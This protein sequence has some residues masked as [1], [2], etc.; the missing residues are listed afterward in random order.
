M[1]DQAAGKEQ[2]V[3]SAIERYE[4]ALMRYAV[5]LTGDGDVARDVVQDTF[6][7][8]WQADPDRL[9]D[10]LAAWLFKV[11]R[12]RALDE[13]RK[14]HR[15]GRI[16]QVPALAGGSAAPDVGALAEIGATHREVLSV[17]ATLPRGQ[18]EVV[19]LRFQGDLSYK[20]ISQVTGYSVGNVGYL[21]HTAL[22]AVRASMAAMDDELRPAA[23]GRSLS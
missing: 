17:L 18:Q 5:S 8:L 11:C 1:A 3:E 9:R 13:R 4:G 22:A 20:Q 12:N 15:M 19:R 14:E 21:L 2:W 23:E 7:R 6:I 10:G 16:D